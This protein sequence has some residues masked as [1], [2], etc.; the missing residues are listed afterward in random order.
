MRRLSGGSWRFSFRLA[1]SHRPAHNLG[2]GKTIAVLCDLPL[3]FAV[4]G[5]CT[6]R[7]EFRLCLAALLCVLVFASIG[8]SAEPK[9]GRAIKVRADQTAV[10]SPGMTRA[11][12]T[13]RLATPSRDGD[14]A[15]H[16]L[17]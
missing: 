4:P 9:R 1:L 11:L 5:N 12:A 2:G 3:F 8:A 14:S 16:Y 13:A 7:L 6:M 15:S 17:L 10:T